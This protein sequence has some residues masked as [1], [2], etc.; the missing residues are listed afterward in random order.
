[1]DVDDLKAAFYRRWLHACR[2]AGLGDPTFEHGVS[3][4]N[5]EEAAYYAGKWGL[6]SEMTK[7]HIKKSQQFGETPFDLLR[8]YFTDGDKQAGLLFKEFAYSFK[9]KRQL[10]WSRGLKAHFQVAEV[11]DDEAA[12][13]S[14]SFAFLLGRIDFDDWRNVINCDRRGDL[15]SLAG[16]SWHHVQDFLLTLRG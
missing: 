14:D 12:Q 5:G 4:H 7:G 15:L 8:A 6:E 11:S 9:G 2:K 1:L 16:I 13:V 10:F 3:V